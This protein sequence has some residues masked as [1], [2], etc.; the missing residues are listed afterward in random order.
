MT[1]GRMRTFRG[2]YICRNCGQTHTYH[3]Q[4]GECLTAEEYAEWSARLQMP[5]TP[6]P[7]ACG[8][9][10]CSPMERD[11]QKAAHPDKDGDRGR[12]IEQQ[13][14]DQLGFRVY[15][16]N[17]RQEWCW[18]RDGQDGANYGASEQLLDLW[19]RLV[20]SQARCAELCNESSAV[21]SFWVR[22]VIKVVAELRDTESECERLREEVRYECE[23]KCAAIDIAVGL[24]DQLDDAEAALSQM[25]EALKNAEW[26]EKM[27]NETPLCPVCGN[28]KRYGHTEEC[29]TRAALAG[30]KQ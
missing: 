27:P 26:V 17:G 18:V 1:G 8:C 16:V 2:S 28:Y 14:A 7:I 4:N 22:H 11:L 20:K 12:T 19:E 15:S 5:G 6:R 30:D 10:M 9:Q 25:R 21:Y 13:L 29:T 3:K 23:Q 24:Q